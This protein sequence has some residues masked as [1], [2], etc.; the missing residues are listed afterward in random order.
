MFFI[1]FKNLFQEKIRLLISAGGVAFAI[2]LMMFLIGIYNGI[3]K[4]FSA[5]PERNPAQIIVSR[6]GITDMFHGVSI[7]SEKD[8][9]A[10]QNTPGID[11]TV[12]MILMPAFYEK[13]GKKQDIFLVSYEPPSS[14]GAPWDIVEGRGIQEKNEIVMDAAFAKKNALELGDRINLVERD[15]TISGFNKGGSTILATF[16]FIQLEEAREILKL[17]EATNFLFASLKEGFDPVE[18]RADIETRTEGLSILTKEE[19]IKNNLAELEETFLPI[20]YIMVAIAVIV[21]IA[22]IGLTVYTATIEKSK[23]YGI[24]KAVG[25]KNLQLYLLI[26]QQ[27]GISTMIGFLAGIILS[28]GVAYLVG[29]YL[30]IITVEFTAGTFAIVFAL[31]VF[32]SFVASYIPVRTIAQIDP[33][34]VFKS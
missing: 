26:F 22:V 34:E 11:E 30:R 2:L 19:F 20:I 8:A 18:V 13:D 10:I 16:A 4:A 5:Y 12:G 3:I 23:E 24:L 1:A 25:V 33:A 28:F 9:K 27:A 17:P 14:L 15:F 7:V 32:M 29:E 31:T 21:G 6:E